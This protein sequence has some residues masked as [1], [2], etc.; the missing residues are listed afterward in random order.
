[1]TPIRQWC[2]RLISQGGWWILKQLFIP[3][4]CYHKGD[5]LLDNIAIAFHKSGRRFLRR[6]GPFQKGGVLAF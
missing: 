2:D 5:Y 1:M 4:D 3:R 6:G